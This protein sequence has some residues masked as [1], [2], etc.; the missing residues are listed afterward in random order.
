MASAEAKE[1]HK[2]CTLNL[3]SCYLNLKQ[4]EQ[5]ISECDAV[6]SSKLSASTVLALS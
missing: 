3:G 2:A 5:C 1:L 4:Y 6:V